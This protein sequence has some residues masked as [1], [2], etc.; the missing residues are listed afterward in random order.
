MC[1]GFIPRPLDSRLA[2]PSGRH[3][4]A[5]GIDLE[6]TF[7]ISTPIANSNLSGDKCALSLCVLD[8]LRL[9]N[10]NAFLA[11]ALHTRPS[12][13]VR[14]NIDDEPGVHLGG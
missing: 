4:L 2:D 14:L 6:A 11:R 1:A 5:L 7:N 12:V 10:K 9:E 3:C 13:T 8:G